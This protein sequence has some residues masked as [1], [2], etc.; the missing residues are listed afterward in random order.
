MPPSPPNFSHNMGVFYS[1]WARLEC[2]MDCS[3]GKL[4]NLSHKRTHVITT[5]IDF[6]KKAQWLRELIKDSDLPTKEQALA[7]LNAIQ[8]DSKRNV[9]AHSYVWVDGEV[10][11][12]IEKNPHGGIQAKIHPFTMSALSD[13]VKN[14]LEHGQALEQAMGITQPELDGFCEAAVKLFSKS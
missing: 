10:I 8:N 3:I 14:I 9:F 12:F 2:L 7:A 13:H 11:T 5:Y 6:G 4:L 1:N